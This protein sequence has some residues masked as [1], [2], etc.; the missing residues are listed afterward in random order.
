VPAPGCGSIYSLASLGAPGGL[1]RG[2]TATDLIVGEY[3]GKPDEWLKVS[4]IFNIL[5]DTVETIAAWRF[6]SSLFVRR[7]IY[8]EQL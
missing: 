2:M 1:I 6:M 7:R 3:R 8:P 4:M 5:S